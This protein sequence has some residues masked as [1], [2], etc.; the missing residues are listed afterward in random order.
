MSTILFIGLGSVGKAVFN[1]FMIRWSKKNLKGVFDKIFVIE[2][3][4]EVFDEMKELMNYINKSKI[5]FKRSRLTK[6][7]YDFELQ[8]VFSKVSN[9]YVYNKQN[10]NNQKLGT[11]FDNPNLVSIYD[12]QKLRA[13]FDTRLKVIID[14][15]VNVGSI[16]IVE[17]CLKNDVNYINT[18][19]EYWESDTDHTYQHRILAN[20]QKNVAKMSDQYDKTGEKLPIIVLEH[21]MNPGMISHFTKLGISYLYKKG[22]FDASK[23]KGSIKFT[24][25]S[26]NNANKYVVKEKNNIPYYHMAMRLNLDTIHVAEMDNQRFKKPRIGNSSNDGT[27]FVN[28]WSIDGYT[29]ES[30]D[31]V[32]IGLGTNEDERKLKKT[33]LIFQQIDHQLIFPDI[34]GMNMKLKSYTPC[35]GIVGLAIPHGE[36]SSL[37]LYLS[38]RNS[39][40]QDYKL[41][42]LLKIIDHTQITNKNHLLGIVDRHLP[43]MFPT[44]TDYRPSVYYV[45]ECCREAQVSIDE[46]RQSEY[47]LPKT[48]VIP[49]TNDIE[50]GADYVGAALFYKSSGTRG[51][52]CSWVGTCVTNDDAIDIL[53]NYGNATTC[54][55]IAGV[56][57]ALNFIIDNYG[58]SYYKENDN[59]SSELINVGG[60]Y[61]PEDL[62]TEYVM[63]TSKYYLGE[64]L[65]YHSDWKLNDVKFN[66]FLISYQE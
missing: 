15:S 12:N 37:P 10:F 65:M 2:P 49:Y 25:F 19:N 56:Y 57:S 28:T 64:I 22:N 16:D 39:H 4:E 42:D 17:W 9:D 11:T 63:K 48:K 55:V 46:M 23:Y 20:R 36:A 21:G 26:N 40:Y 27:E 30:I 45:Y 7:N 24:K 8:S 5:I 31:C 41:N 62:P 1:E 33:G 52:N 6:D 13:N 43:G 35:G 18:A 60:I 29:E 59:E 58:T 3:R 34:K 50:S 54:Q 47:K 38:N 66:D 44:N 53:D 32:Q 14:L 51:Y 61:Y